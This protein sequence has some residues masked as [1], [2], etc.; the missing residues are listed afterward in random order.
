MVRPESWTSP[1]GVSPTRVGTGAPGSRPQHVGETRRAERGVKSL[2]GGSKRAGRS[3]KRILQPRH[4]N[5][6]GAEPL[7]SR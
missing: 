7:M 1:V 6:E 4:R 5:N 3:I 2:F